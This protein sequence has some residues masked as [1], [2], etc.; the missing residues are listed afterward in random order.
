MKKLIALATLALSLCAP[1][2]FGQGVRNEPETN[3]PTNL[4]ITSMYS[5]RVYLN[6]RVVDI[7]R[8]AQRA[9]IVRSR[10]GWL[11]VQYQRGSKTYEGWIRR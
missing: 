7:L 9:K 4:Y 5:V 3:T 6:N 10:G 2:A 8:P 11:Y 1:A